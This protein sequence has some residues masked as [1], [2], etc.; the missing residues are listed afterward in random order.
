MDWKTTVCPRSSAHIYMNYYKFLLYFYCFFTVLSLDINLQ[1]Y[2]DQNTGQNTMS[3]KLGFLSGL[4]Q[5]Q[6]YSAEKFANNVSNIT[7]S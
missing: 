5:S 3:L 2:N 1:I 4:P 7:A 6:K